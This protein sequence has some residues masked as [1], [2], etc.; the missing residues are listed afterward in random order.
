M[1]WG[2]LVA[3]GWDRKDG[4]CQPFDI[5]SCDSFTGSWPFA[6]PKKFAWH[7]I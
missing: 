2:K 4:T 3:H 1:K 5:G 6:S 7:S